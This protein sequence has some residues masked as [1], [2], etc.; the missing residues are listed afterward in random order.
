MN[1]GEKLRHLRLSMKKTLKQQGEIFN[2]TANSVYRWEHNLAAPRRPVLKRIAEYYS[3]PL[4]WLLMEGGADE[5]GDG[6]DG[7]YPESDT[8]QQ[9]VKIFRKLPGNCKYKVLGYLERIYIEALDGTGAE[10][11]PQAEYAGAV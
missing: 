1:V 3:V 11:D 4:V 6:A 9:L 2:V 10:N 7:I 5:P 8:E